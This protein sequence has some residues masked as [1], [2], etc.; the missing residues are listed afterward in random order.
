[1]AH[2]PIKCR[3]CGL[4]LEDSHE[5]VEDREIENRTR[6]FVGDEEVCSCARKPAVNPFTS[7]RQPPDLDYYDKKK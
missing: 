3:L 5:H 7:T 1:M 4:R 2:A 6:R